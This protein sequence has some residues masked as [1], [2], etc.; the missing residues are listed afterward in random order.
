MPKKSTDPILDELVLIKKLLVLK[1]LTEGLTQSQ[2]ATV[3]GVDQSVISRM[4]PSRII[5]SSRKK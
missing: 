2:I 1:L 5:K 4:V 3:L